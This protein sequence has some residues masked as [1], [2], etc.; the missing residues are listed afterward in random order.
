MVQDKDIFQLHD[1]HVEVTYQQHWNNQ[2][3]GVTTSTISY[4]TFFN[5]LE[6]AQGQEATVTNPVELYLHL[7]EAFGVVSIIFPKH[8]ARLEYVQNR[9]VYIT[10]I[11]GGTEQPIF[12]E[13]N[14]DRSRIAVRFFVTTQRDIE[15]ESIQVYRYNGVFA[16]TLRQNDL[17]PLPALTNTFKQTLGGDIHINGMEFADMSILIAKIPARGRVATEVRRA[18]NEAKNT[19]TVIRWEDLA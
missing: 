10:Q 14:A 16:G 3:C 19:D 2:L 13:L 5:M 9:G 6:E 1:N 12:S 18:I 17:T 15:M 11:Y 7:L 4:P 8:L